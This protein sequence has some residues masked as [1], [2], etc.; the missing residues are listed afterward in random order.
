MSAHYLNQSRIKTTTGLS[1]GCIELNFLILSLVGMGIISFVIVNAFSPIITF[2]KLLPLFLALLFYI[3][4]NQLC[5]N[6]MGNPVK[7][8]IFYVSVL[9][10]SQLLSSALG[11][12]EWAFFPMLPILIIP[13]SRRLKES[14]LILLLLSSFLLYFFWET[15]FHR[16]ALY[17]LLSEGKITGNYPLFSIVYGT[18]LSLIL[19]ATK[20]FSAILKPANEPDSALLKEIYAP[21]MV[22]T[23]RIDVGVI[24]VEA[25]APFRIVAYNNWLLKLLRDDKF[26]ADFQSAIHQRVTEIFPEISNVLIQSRETSEVV[27]YI[28]QKGGKRLRI[29]VVYT[30][31]DISLLPPHFVVL[32]DSMKSDYQVSWM[33]NVMKLILLSFLQERG[34]IYMDIEPFLR[35]LANKFLTLFDFIQSFSV[36]NSVNFMPIVQLGDTSRNGSKWKD[37]LRDCVRSCHITVDPQN[38][39]VFIP[40]ALA[41]RCFLDELSYI[42]VMEVQED[43]IDE[44]KLRYLAV[45]FQETFVPTI[46]FV[47][48]I[49]DILREESLRRNS[50]LRPLFHRMRNLIVSLQSN[51]KAID[52]N[53]IEAYTENLARIRYITS[54]FSVFLDTVSL[55]IFKERIADICINPQ[56]HTKVN[57]RRF[58]DEIMEPF[59][60][61]LKVLNA[62]VRKNIDFETEEVKLPQHIFKLIISNVMM[63][64]VEN[65]H[66]FKISYSEDFWG[67]DDMGNDFQKL[68]L[69]IDGSV[70]EDEIILRFSVPDRVFIN[71]IAMPDDENLKIIKD[72]TLTHAR[73]FL[74][75]CFGGRMYSNFESDK[76]TFV[77]ATFIPLTRQ[78]Q[79]G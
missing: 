4:K 52:T 55:S 78:Q 41:N 32:V 38:N 5:E 35:E 20:Y 40:M 30:S 13:F 60:S 61:Y 70:K 48:E 36:Y 64:E 68:E 57:I 29:S 37:K 6:L 59:E 9:L 22:L 79:E 73:Q 3:L 69:T 19:L 7:F 49:S 8:K 63:L 24:I 1:Q 43:K 11:T 23:N 39:V 74:I 75:Q 66:R 71:M 65:I 67:V 42:V 76:G 14:S 21:V 34:E 50:V 27:D 45:M 18:Y 16:A 15:I 54:V 10:F 58:L 2:L 53:D 62:G 26:H 25:Q 56:R 72:V 47:K 33:K 12:T 31:D 77:I 51:I 46:Y 28:M 44:E 17:N